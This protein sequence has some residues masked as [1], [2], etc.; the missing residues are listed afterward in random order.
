MKSIVSSNPLLFCVCICLA[1]VSAGCAGGGGGHQVV[2]PLKK[3]VVLKNYAHL[4]LVAECNK[5]GT[6]TPAI[7]KRISDMVVNEVKKTQPSRFQ[8]INPETAVPGTIRYRVIFTKYDRGDAF[9]RAMLAGLGQI[10]IDADIYVEDPATNEVLA[11][12]K[13]AKTFAWGGIYGG[14]VT[15]EGVEPG[16]A[17][18][19]ATV[20][21]E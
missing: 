6:M 9:A 10:H 7:A 11:K 13:V 15:I 5:V 3:G 2:Q 16:F 1:G 20:V 4:E 17:K 18:G 8:Q 12:Y 21:L 14:S 19:V